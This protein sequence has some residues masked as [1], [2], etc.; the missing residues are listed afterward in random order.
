MGKQH[1]RHLVELSLA[2]IF[3]STSGALGRYIDMPTPVIIWARSILAL[4][5]LYVYCRI[6]GI[7]LRIYSKRDATGF[8]IGGLFLGAHWI[9]YFYALKW[10]NVAFGMLSLHTFPV[11]IVLLE[12]FFMRTKLDYVHILLG[13]L[14][15]FGIY[16][17][18]PEFDFENRDVQGILMGLFS[19]LCYALRILIL[20]TYVQ[21]YNGTMLMLHQLVVLSIV[22]LPVLFVMETSGFKTQWP[23]ILLLAFLTTAIGHTLFVRSLKHFSASTAG[24]ITSALPIYGIIIAFFFLGEIPSW[25]TYIGGL[26]IVSTVIIE[27]IRSKKK[28]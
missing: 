23:Y 17:L 8:L 9:T 4:I 15:L 24:I 20:K 14:V 10:S 28:H 21:R 27:S 26:L 6:R 18:S 2:T 19:A 7:D 11:M 25:N 22:L 3:I 13:L 1:L 12:P 16:V 5:V